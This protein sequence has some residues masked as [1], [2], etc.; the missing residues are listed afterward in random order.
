MSD[1]QYA[2]QTIRAWIDAGPDRASAE[3]VDRTLT[4]IPRMRQRRSWR[5][6][7]GRRV[8]PLLVPTAAAAAVLAVAI[9]LGSLPNGMPI[10]GAGPTSSPSPALGSS[11]PTFELK[12]G[13]GAS[14]RVFRSDPTAS[15]Q[16]CNVKSTGP[17]YALYA[18][19]D[20]FVNI[21][22]LVGAGAEKPGGASRVASE[23]QA[24]DL[25]VRFDP[26]ILRGGDAAGRS[27][28]TVTITTVGSATT[29]LVDATTPDSHH[30]DVPIH[31]S[32]T[33]TC[34]P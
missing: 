5:I 31:V 6:E 12:F 10:G 28:A 13:D 1:E 20:P 21:D 18:G 17:S 23:I 11:R 3:F 4:P 29:F 24:D 16:T 22:F 19:G 8:G 26:A 7:L 34:A 30:G 27:Q 32:L 25:Y 14:A 9:V 33:L 15:V 2:D